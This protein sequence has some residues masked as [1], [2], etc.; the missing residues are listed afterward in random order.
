MEPSTSASPV[1]QAVAIVTAANTAA[2]TAVL[3]D[4][5]IAAIRETESPVADTTDPVSSALSTTRSLAAWRG[6]SRSTQQTRPAGVTVGVRNDRDPM[7]VKFEEYLL[8]NLR[9]SDVCKDDDGVYMF[10][11]NQVAYLV[12]G[13]VSKDDKR[14]TQRRVKE[15]V[16]SIKAKIYKCTSY[17]KGETTI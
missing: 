10:N 13:S 4:K 11:V 15:G 3:T 1:V 9:A 17:G 6:Q 8:G 16:A 2:N 12:E 14:T 5:V 7:L